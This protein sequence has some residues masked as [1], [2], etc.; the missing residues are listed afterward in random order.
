MEVTVVSQFG[1]RFRPHYTE[2]K[3][4][5]ANLEIPRGNLQHELVE[6]PAQLTGYR[7]NPLLETRALIEF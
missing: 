6:T 7:I 3:K 2:G 1:R 5:Y 4:P